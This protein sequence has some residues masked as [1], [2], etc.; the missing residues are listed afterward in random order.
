MS[1]VRRH[2]Y[3]WI[4]PTRKKKMHMPPARIQFYILTGHLWLEAKLKIYSAVNLPPQRWLWA[5]LQQRSLIAAII[6]PDSLISPL[7]A[8][9]C[10]SHTAQL[11]IHWVND[12]LA[13]GGWITFTHLQ[14][15]LGI[16]RNENALHFFWWQTKLP[17]CSQ[18]WQF[19]QIKS[20][21]W[22]RQDFDRLW[23][24]LL[25]FPFFG[26]FLLFETPYQ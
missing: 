20:S 22:G 17:K 8:S 19:E 2:H 12:I 7:A 24:H 11:W 9:S 10:N 14:Y 26:S 1:K 3:K 25:G 6:L 21:Q 4:I 15:V 23:Q 5:M 18:P 13:G 16:T